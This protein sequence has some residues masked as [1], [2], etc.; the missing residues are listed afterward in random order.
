MHRLRY[1]VPRKTV[2]YLD[3]ASSARERR[4]GYR[5]FGMVAGRHASRIAALWAGV[6]PRTFVANEKDKLQRSSTLETRPN[7]YCALDLQDCL[8]IAQRI[9]TLAFIPK[10]PDNRT[11]FGHASDAFLEGVHIDMDHFALRGIIAADHGPVS[12]RSHPRSRHKLRE[13]AKPLA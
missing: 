5:H 12:F 8:M 10:C 9:N 7:E 4:L 2:A 6:D 3:N 11:S 13:A 1:R